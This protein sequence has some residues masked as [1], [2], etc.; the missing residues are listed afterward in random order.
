MSDLTVS[1]WIEAGKVIAADQN[2]E[3]LCPVCKFS[4]LTVRDEVFDIDR[5]RCERHMICMHCGATNSILMRKNT[6]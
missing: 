3:V 6:A 4:A 1:A 2:A 5:T